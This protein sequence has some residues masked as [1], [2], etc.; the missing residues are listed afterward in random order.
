MSRKKRFTV[1]SFVN[2]DD[3]PTQ[4]DLLVKTQ[5]YVNEVVGILREIDG[6]I[7][8]TITSIKVEVTG[9]E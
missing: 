9:N 1:N 8:I 7:T 2:V 4:Q 6:E 3:E 5:A